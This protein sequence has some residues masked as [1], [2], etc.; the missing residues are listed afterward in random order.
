MRHSLRE[1]FLRLL[2]SLQR[3]KFERE[4][5]EEVQAHL[6]L[7][8]ERFIQ[9][10]LSAEEARYAARRQFGGVTQMRDN[11]RERSRF[12]F[13]EAILQDSAYVIRQL[14]RSPLF[15]TAAILTLALGIGANTAIFSFVDQLILR[16][17]PVQNPQEIVSLVGQGEHYGSNMGHNVLSYPIYQDFRD[18]NQVFRQMMCRRSVQFT[19]TAQ[20]QSEVISGEL[21]SGN[22]F[23]LL[24][25]KAAVGWVFDSKDDLHQNAHP[26]AVL[27]YAYWK[28]QFAGNPAAIGQTILINNY[29]LTII[30]VT[31]PSFEGLEPGLPTQI[32]VPV[33]MTPALFPTKDFS[34]IFDRRLRWINVYGR[35]KPGVT[36]KMA[37]AG[38]QPLFHQIL[39]MEVRE[40]G[41]AH[42]TPYAKEQFLKMRLNVLPGG[43]GNTILRRQY[44]K[45]LFV[46]MG[47]TGFVLLIACANLAS[48]LAAKAATRQK[49]VAVRLAIGSSRARIVQQLLTES[50]VLAIGG[51]VAGIWVAVLMTKG[52]ITFLPNNVGGYT[53]ST[54]PNERV[55]LFTFTVSVITGIVFGLAPALQTTNPNIAETLKNQASS[56]TGGLAHINFRKM[57]VAAQIALSLL[58]LVGASLFVRSLA[59]LRSLD[60]GFQTQNL[61]QFELHLDAIG[62]NLNQA[63]S[64]YRELE[65]RL[66]RI[67]LVR[68]AG[69]AD[70]AVLANDDWENIITVA[71]YRA[72]PGENTT[73]YMNAASP[74]YFETMGIHLLSGRVFRESDT[75][76]SPKV[77]VVNQSFAK[78]FFG[79]EP[80]V[81][82]RIGRGGDSNTPTDLE[83]IGVV[84]DTDYDNLEQKA[85]RQV[86]LCAA[87]S[88]LLGATVYA[89]V[90]GDPRSAFGPI[91]KSVHDMEP[92]APVIDM[93]TVEH[94]LDESLATER[95][96]A[97]LS[98]GFSIL[99]TALSVLGL[100]GVMA[101]MVAQRA[102]EIGIRIAL[103]AMYGNVIWLVMREVLLLIVIGITMALPLVFGLSRL[104][105]SQLYGVQPADS[106]SIIFAMLVLSAVALV[107]GYIPARRAAASDSLRVLRYE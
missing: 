43:Q 3:R 28:S 37:E 89:K 99:A 64:F 36:P 16:L 22:Y 23:P 5:D 56:V 61:V 94:Q 84:N 29:R 32:F 9:Q 95:M 21:V 58:L 86:F 57:L 34:Q 83:I 74:G 17:L 2:G 72:R 47:L 60:P 4:F 104:V 7:L 31:Q 65:E 48:L 55:L 50:L 106:A 52:L 10:G 42:A 45:P 90:Q 91:K 75:A 26:L 40:P 93:K 87:Q 18:R 38:L 41:F 80:A 66:Q 77:V 46:L 63:L 53:I 62:Y 49:E 20:S 19:A 88:H 81:G 97:T 85:P 27:G 59:H 8:A 24:G 39:A 1:L 51:G 70:T 76:V 96:I 100:Y 35:L 78:H 15:A 73:C 30:G 101:Y 98:T 69:I 54:A 102:R 79:N 107:A 44:Q 6:N 68:S 33:S 13:L 67:P 82:R 105:R 92:K 12:S 25:V 11:L 103:G 14:R 71:G